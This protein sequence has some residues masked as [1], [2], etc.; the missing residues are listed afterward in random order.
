MGED[1]EEAEC[2]C[3]VELVVAVLVGALCGRWISEYGHDWIGEPEMI[4]TFAFTTL[5]PVS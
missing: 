2:Q 4:F 5:Q 3:G 1:G